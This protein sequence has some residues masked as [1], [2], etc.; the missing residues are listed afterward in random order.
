MKYHRE[1]THSHALGAIAAIVA[2]TLVLSSCGRPQSKAANHSSSATSTNAAT[3]AVLR[4]SPEEDM[5]TN[6]VSNPVFFVLWMSLPNE[7]CEPPNPQAI[8]QF[9]V[10]PA[11]EQR[12]VY[13]DRIYTTKSQHDAAMALLH[14]TLTSHSTGLISGGDCY[15]VD[16]TLTQ[17]YFR[18]GVG[19]S[20][21]LGMIRAK[22]VEHVNDFQITTAA[23]P[24]E[25]R[26]YH[27]NYY[28]DGPNSGGENLSGVTD[29]MFKATCVIVR[30]N[31][32]NRWDI[33]SCQPT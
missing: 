31:V 1:Y 30:N 33:Q 2:L 6:A 23:G 26:S 8:A 4:S 25:A 28:V 17:R 5:L 7:Y 9:R 24:A 13:I 12:P 27:V 10:T 32:E 16:P 29:V 21:P 19:V 20:I 3:P 15:A 22:T 14:P 11:V 18:P